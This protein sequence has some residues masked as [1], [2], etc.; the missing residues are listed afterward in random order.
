MPYNRTAFTLD[1]LSN[2]GMRIHTGTDD[3]ESEWSCSW[4]RFTTIVLVLSVSVLVRFWFELSQMPDT[5]SSWLGLT[6]IL[7]FVHASNA[8]IYAFFF[9]GRSCSSLWHGLLLGKG[10]DWFY[11]LSYLL[12]SPWLSN[13]LSSIS[14]VNKTRTWVHTKVD[15][16]TNNFAGGENWAHSSCN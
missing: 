13:F 1:D 16:S 2:E 7:V 14:L 8:C 15:N 6:H 9:R 3:C 12:Y 5:I 10:S 11:G 4:R